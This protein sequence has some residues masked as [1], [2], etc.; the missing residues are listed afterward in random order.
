MTEEE[1]EG[2]HDKEQANLYQGSHDSAGTG[3]INRILGFVP[4]IALPRIIGV[5]GVGLYQLC[6]PFL[7]VLLTLITGGIPLAV[8]KWIAEADSK[9]D[10][11]RVRQIFRTAMSLTVTLAVIMTVLMLACADWITTRLLTDSRVYQAFIMMAPMLLVIGISSVYRGY[12][13]G[14]QNMIPTAQS[15]VVETVLRIAAQLLLAAMF[16]PM[17]LAWPLPERCWEP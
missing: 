4:R 9:G 8:A 15:Q 3:M 2:N 13:Q 10:G 6:Y 1:K 5:E 14:K 17:G 11:F 7:G 12:F 16:L